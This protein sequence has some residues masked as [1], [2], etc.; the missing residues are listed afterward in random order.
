MMTMVMMMM[1]WRILNR[2][3]AFFRDEKSF[4]VWV[5][6]RGWVRAL[7]QRQM[8][9]NVSSTPERFSRIKAFVWCHASVGTSW[10]ETA[11]ISYFE[12]NHSRIWSLRHLTKVMRRHDLTNPRWSLINEKP[13]GH[14]KIDYWSDK[15][16]IFYFWSN[17]WQPLRRR[18]DCHFPPVTDSPQDPAPPGLWASWR[19]LAGRVGFCNIGRRFS[20]GLWSRA[21]IMWQF[22]IG[23]WSQSAGQLGEDIKMSHH[24]YRRSSSSAAVW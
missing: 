2:L 24:H 21:G 17:I 9:L 14:Q 10:E 18:C 11:Q 5:V 23:Q 16:N 1:I 22:R 6:K 3:L 4:F 13:F 7:K 19:P 12:L 15:I 8:G 20:E